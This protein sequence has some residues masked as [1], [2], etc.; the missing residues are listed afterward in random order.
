MKHEPIDDH[1][2][3]KR[4]LSLIE[5]CEKEQTMSDTYKFRRSE[6]RREIQDACYSLITEPLI[7]EEVYMRIMMPLEDFLSDHEVKGAG[8]EI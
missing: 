2:E 1:A 8:D 3:R 5:R 6:I 7:A 4:I